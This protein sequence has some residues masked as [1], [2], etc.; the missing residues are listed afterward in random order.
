MTAIVS[1]YPRD[2]S[3][4]SYV[5]AVYGPGMVVLDLFVGL[6]YDPGL[7]ARILYEAGYNG[8]LEDGQYF[9]WRQRRTVKHPNGTQSFSCPVNLWK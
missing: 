2:H 5:L 1:V 3:D 8:T 9:E 4:R 7:M 6:D